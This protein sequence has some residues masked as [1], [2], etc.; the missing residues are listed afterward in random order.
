MTSSKKDPFTIGPAR[1]LRDDEMAPLHAMLEANPRT[2][3][4]RA[5]LP[6][7]RVQ[8][9]DDGGMGSL[10]V[11]GS[12]DRLFGR[13]STEAWFDDLDGTKVSVAIILDRQGALYELDV[14]KVDNTPLRQLPAPRVLRD[15]TIPA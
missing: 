5:G 15:W 10:R 11:V 6:H 2:S 8:A 9:L 14:W 4:M 1:G 3:P 7:M 12:E 13:I